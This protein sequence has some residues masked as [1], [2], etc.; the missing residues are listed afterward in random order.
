MI[1]L[2]NDQTV[3]YIWRF[4]NLRFNYKTKEMN[5]AARTK[6]LIIDKAA[7]IFNSKG[8]A[9]TSLSD[10]LEATKL[11]KGSLYVHFEN[12]EAISHAVVDHFA[13]RKIKMLDRVFSGKDSSSA[14]D[15]LFAYLELVLN[16][17]KPVFEGGCPFLNFGMEADDMDQVIRKKVKKMVEAEQGRIAGAVSLGIRN[18]D[19]RPDWDAQEFATTVYA[20]VE[21]ATMITRVS[22]SGKSMKTVAKFLKKEIMRNAI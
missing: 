10:I 16:P 17:S 5:K 14:K 20:M 13:D 18:G 11:A 3:S 4:L 1:R 7:P 19:F 15:R 6:Q 12:K 22:S 2:Y 8:I 9:G 21:G